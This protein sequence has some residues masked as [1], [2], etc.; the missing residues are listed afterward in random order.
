MCQSSEWAVLWVLG[1]MATAASCSLPHL[2]KIQCLSRWQGVKNVQDTHTV[3]HI[4][5]CS[6]TLPSCFP[7]H[8]AFRATV[9]K[10]VICDL[11]LWFISLTQLNCLSAL[12]VHITSSS[13]DDIITEANPILHTFLTLLHSHAVEP[14][15]IFTFAFT[16]KQ[17]SAGLA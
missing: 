6:A 16:S 2:D 15:W 1:F 3:T 10:S 14:S 8:G 17:N 12:S 7:P 4:H 9:R 13:V 5:T 11:R